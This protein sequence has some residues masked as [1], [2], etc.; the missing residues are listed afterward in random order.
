MAVADSSASQATSLKRLT[1]IAVVFLPLSLAS[2]LLAMTESVQAVGEHWFDCL[3]LW[4]TMGFVVARVYALWRRIDYL[5]ARPLAGIFIS[6]FLGNLQSLILPWLVPL[7]CVIVVSSWVPMLDGLQTVLEALKWGFVALR[8]LWCIIRHTYKAFSY[9]F[10]GCEF[11]FRLKRL[12]GSFEDISI[13]ISTFAPADA[14]K[15][16]ELSELKLH[17]LVERILKATA[18]SKHMKRSIRAESAVFRQIRIEAEQREDQRVK[19]MV[20]E[21]RNFPTIDNQVQELLAGII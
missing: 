16:P 8:L 11:Y 14:A 21:I 20:Q 5:Q 13:I 19:E 15:S 2:S 7:F 3:G 18:R 12:G 10:I 4:L 9:L 6:Q 1:I 17:G